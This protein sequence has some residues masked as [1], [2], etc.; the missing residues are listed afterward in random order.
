MIR[1]FVAALL[2]A[3]FAFQLLLGGAGSACAPSGR[4]GHMAMPDGG[5]AAVAARGH[6]H[7]HRDG[8]PPCDH[9]GATE[10]CQTMA[11][12]A[13]ISMVAVSLARVA[14]ADVPVIVV[15][16]SVTAPSSRTIP[17]ELPPPRA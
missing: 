4:D 5:H 16:S 17:P 6:V 7:G 9:R 15:S 14:P 13:G 1:S 3:S 10:A 12:C 11:P 2:S 8:K